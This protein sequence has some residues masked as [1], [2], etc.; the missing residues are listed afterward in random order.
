M[1]KVAQS[2]GKPVGERGPVAGHER[3]IDGQPG[4]MT[5]PGLVSR[6]IRGRTGEVSSPAVRVWR[7]VRQD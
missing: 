2:R 7:S 5:G 6:E 4:K 3:Q 1:V